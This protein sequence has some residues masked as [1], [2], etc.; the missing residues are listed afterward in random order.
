MAERDRWL[1]R[2]DEEDLVE[3]F[4][5]EYDEG[6]FDYYDDEYYND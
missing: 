1:D 6:D 3:D 4:D 5:D 2:D